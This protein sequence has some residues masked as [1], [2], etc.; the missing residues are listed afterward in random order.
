MTSVKA[1]PDGYATVTPWIISRD[2]AAVLDFLS[3]AF[4]A[5]ETVRVQGED[6]FIGHAETRIGDAPVMLFDSRPH[7]PATPAFLRLYVA[8]IASAVRRAADAGAQIVTRPTELHFGD[9]VARVRD[10]LGNVYWLHQHVTDPTPD[11]LAERER[12]P[13][14]VEGMRYV[15][16]ADIFA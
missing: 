5:V 11:E 3:K 9:I 2:T 15:S 7:W 10:P 12:R 13:E 1:V 4:D 16:G 8:D 6:G 14:F